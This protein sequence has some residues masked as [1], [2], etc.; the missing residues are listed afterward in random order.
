MLGIDPNPFDIVVADDGSD[1]RTQHIIECAKRDTGLTIK[2]V[3]HEDSGFQKSAIL[4]KATLA[5]EGEY[6]IFTDG[7]CIPRHD[8]VQTHYKEGT[9]ADLLFAMGRFISHGSGGLCESPQGSPRRAQS[10]VPFKLDASS[11]LIC[12]LEDVSKPARERQTCPMLRN[13]PK[14][15]L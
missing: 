13:M 11:S 3:W 12:L 8:F 14:F 4:N 15:A 6:L 9:V 7:D 5:A 2:H 1:E 10:V